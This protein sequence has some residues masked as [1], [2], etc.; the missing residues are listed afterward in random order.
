M[1]VRQ[2]TPADT[3]LVADVLARAAQDLAR[4]GHPLWSAQ[5]VSEAVVGPQVAQGLYYV[6]E[7][8]AGVAGVFRF[9]L[10]DPM[11]WPEMQEGDAAYLHKVA[12][13]PARQGR[14]EAQRLLAAACELARSRGLRYLRLDC[15]GGR[16]KLREVYE[17]FGFR[18]HSDKVFGS[19]VFHRFELDLSA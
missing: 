6:G 15:M 7:D 13:P 9:E 1:R 17:R 18:H 8:G 3:A 11:F 10:R 16:P 14:D 5:E 2:A 19:T 4:R 12:V